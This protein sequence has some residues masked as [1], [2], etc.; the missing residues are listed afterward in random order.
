MALNVPPLRG[1]AVAD[2]MQL[3]GS[4]HLTVRAI[5]ASEEWEGTIHLIID[6]EHNVREGELTVDGPGGSW[7]GALG[8]VLEFEPRGSLRL[9]ALF[10]DPDTE[11]APVVVEVGEEEA[12]TFHVNVAVE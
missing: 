8:E 12:G 4:R 11:V 1:E 10:A 6:E 7:S 5:D 2:E 9:R 3:D